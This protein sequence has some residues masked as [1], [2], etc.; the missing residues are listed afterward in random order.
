MV[1]FIL[2]CLVLLFIVALLGAAGIVGG[3]WYYGRGLPDY[4]QLADYQPPVV[5]RLHAAD[6]RLMTEYAAEKRVFVPVKAIPER[7]I[8]AFLSAEDKTFYQHKGVDFWGI[9]RAAVTNFRNAGEGKRMVGASTIT[10]QVAKNFL[11]TNERSVARKAKEAILAFR[12][13]Q[14]YNKDQILELY[15]NEIYL[16]G[17]SYGVAAAA[18]DYFNKSLDELTIEEAAYLAALPKAPNNYNPVKHKAEALARRNWVID[19]MNENGYVTGAEAAAAK[20]ED[21]VMRQRADTAYVDAEYFAEEARRE[22]LEKYGEKGLYGG[23]LSVRTSLQPDLQ[24]VA[25]TALQNGLQALDHRQGWRGP[26]THVPNI[27]AWLP[28]LKTVGVPKGGEKWYLAAVLSV[29]NTAATVGFTDGAKGT[30]AFDDMKWARPLVKGRMGAFP[31]SPAD[32]LKIGDVIM[33]D[34]VADKKESYALKQVPLVEGA[35]MALDPHT[36]R[37]YAM[38][39]GF[40]PAMGSFNRAIQ[41]KRQPGSSFKPFVYLAALEQGFLP[42][43]LVLDAPITYNLGYGLGTWSPANYTERFY[44]PT[45]LRAGIEKSRNVM[46]VRLADYIGMDK[47]A[48]ISKRFGIIDNMPK[49]LAMALGAGETTLW[50]LTTAYAEL[51]N[52]GRKITPSLIDR[53]QDRHGKTL[54]NHDARICQTCTDKTWHGQDV[55]ELP[56]PRAILTDP[57]HAYQIVSMLEGVTQRG[58][59]AKLKALNRPLAGKTGTTNDYK[60]TWFIGMTPDL[61]VGIWIGFDNPRS[62]GSKETGGSVAVPVFEEFVKKSLERCPADTV[63]YPARHAAAE[64][65]S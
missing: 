33:V 59:A 26:I 53:V 60:D 10:Q 11:L 1:R 44:G 43:T 50:K 36:G 19:R 65:L 47:V 49:Q 55:P 29:S 61:V 23:G 25:T 51:L 37:V 20:K 5:T 48:E 31:K 34:A 15:L 2:W 8:A 17:G 4:R 7:V 13:E 40:S 12:I 42:T 27:A 24:T 38:T 63:S 16:G 3:L 57:M 22:L 9:A 35:I 56:D 62:L 32:V 64:S 46:T 28:F 45:P 6:G 39:G 30:I 14:T 18:M 21:L 58:T 52:G 54:F 41:A